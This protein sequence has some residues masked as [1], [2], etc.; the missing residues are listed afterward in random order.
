M[1]TMKAAVLYGDRDLRVVDVPRPRAE[2]NSVLIRVNNVGVCGT[3]LHTYKLGM[4]KE[5]CLPQEQGLLF[6]HEFAG[7]VVEIG[8]DSGSEDLRPGD[9]VTGIAIGAYAEYCNVPPILGDKP[10]I[11]KLPDNVSFEEAATVE[12]LTVSLVAVQRAALKGGERVLITGAGMIGLGCVQVIKALHPDCEVIISDVADKRL[13]MAREFGADRIVNV[14]DE[15]LVG[16]LKA[17]TGEAFVFYGSGTTAH[18]DVAIEASGLSGP[19]NQCLEVLR[20]ETGR[21]VGVALYEHKPE[22]DFNQ[23]VSKNLSVTGTLGYSQETME[24]ALN[25]I[26]EGKVDRKPLITHKYRLAEASEAF[27]AQLDAAETL[28]AIIKP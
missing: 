17:L 25:L 7:E 10:L 12:P 11:I 8:S 6:G 15:D 26:A 28:K 5:M 1:D 18:I 9:R 27:E 23:I 24:Q 14:R 22:V 21:L 3:D 16:S 19:L 4:F 20:P 13:E 2:A